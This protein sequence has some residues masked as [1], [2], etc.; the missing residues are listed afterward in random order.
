[1]R[2]PK[3]DLAQL[4]KQREENFRERLEFIEWYVAWLR[5][6]PNMKWSS[7]QKKIVDRV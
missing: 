1:M 7:H 5:R 3:I 6:A 4:K 2:T